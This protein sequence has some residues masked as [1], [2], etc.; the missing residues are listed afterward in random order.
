MNDLFIRFDDNGAPIEYAYEVDGCVD[1]SDLGKVV[2]GDLEHTG[3]VGAVPYI[4]G[5]KAEYPFPQSLD[6]IG[7]KIAQR[8]RDAVSLYI[9]ETHAGADELQ[10]TLDR[11]N[12]EAVAASA[13]GFG[14]ISNWKHWNFQ[15]LFPKVRTVYFIA[16]ADALTEMKKVNVDTSTRVIYVES[17]VLAFDSKEEFDA[18]ITR[19]E[20]IQTSILR[21]A[22]RKL[23]DIRLVEKEKRDQEEFQTAEEWE[24]IGTMEPFETAS[25]EYYKAQFAPPST[26]VFQ[27]LVNWLNFIGEKGTFIHEGRITKPYEAVTTL[28][29]KS[30]GKSTLI[31]ACN[32]RA[33]YWQD[34]ETDTYG[35]DALS[36]VIGYGSAAGLDEAL[37]LNAS[38]AKN[39]GVKSSGA[40]ITH[41]EAQDIFSSTRGGGF[42]LG[43]WGAFSSIYDGTYNDKLVVGRDCAFRSVG[44]QFYQAGFNFGIQPKCFTYADSAKLESQGFDVRSLFAMIPFI[45]GMGR[46]KSFKGVFNGY[47]DLYDAAYNTTDFGIYSFDEKA[48]EFYNDWETK[49]QIRCDELHGTPLFAYVNRLPQHAKKFALGLSIA[50]EIRKKGFPELDDV[51]LAPLDIAEHAVKLAEASV[52]DRKKTL[53]FVDLWQ[54]KDVG[55]TLTTENELRKIYDYLLEERSKGNVWVS[56]TKLINSTPYRARKKGT[57]TTDYVKRK[58]L[59]EEFLRRGWGVAMDGSTDADHIMKNGVKLA[60]AQ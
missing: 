16:K 42:T 37:S 4:A 41:H 15:C 18:L 19:G 40:S 26:C 35:K 8:R 51:K 27:M 52:I 24:P 34:F 43:E 60:A 44:R 7:K 33:R 1:V 20:R 56:Q 46:K 29:E 45:K 17:D 59:L 49:N 28:G 14:Y 2:G 54:G 12:I 57:D 47:Y 21:D 38:I 9:T 3:V 13:G 22:D 39:R 23:A 36:F 53:R 6:D 31:D 5:G 30:I 11:F 10:T 58:A 55:L 50:Y 48:L 32:E 25:I